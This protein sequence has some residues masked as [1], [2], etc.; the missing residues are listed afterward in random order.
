M[1][2]DYYIVKILNI[3]YNENDYLSVEID[4]EGGDYNF[5]YDED[6]DDYEYKLKEYIKECLTTEK[7]PIII[8]T[9]NSFNKVNTEMKYKRII[10]NK[11]NKNDKKW[12]EITKILKVEE[13]FE[14]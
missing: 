5:Q 1:G 14:R 7:E 2:W 13:R 11:L 3:Y 6:N 10:E 9:E 8:Y 4:R 12:C